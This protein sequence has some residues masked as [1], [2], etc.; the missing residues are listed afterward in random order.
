VM[1]QRKISSFSHIAR[2]KVNQGFSSFPPGKKGQVWIE[3]VIYTLIGLAVIGILLAVAMPKINSMKD[4]IA[5]EKSIESLDLI[6]DKINA[7]RNAPGNRREISL[8]ISKGKFIIDSEND[9]LIWEIPSSY[10]YSEPGVEVVNGNLKILTTESNPWTI[11]IWTDYNVDITFDNTDTMN[12]KEFEKASTSY[13]FYIEN[14]GLVD[15]KVVV[16]LRE[17]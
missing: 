17:G 10:K 1:F 12:T 8:D 13:T 6:N 3:T 16:D 5:I 14:M 9:K 11:R 15:N 4:K 2:K 7:V